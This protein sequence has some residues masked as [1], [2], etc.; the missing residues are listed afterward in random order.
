MAQLRDFV[1]EHADQLAQLLDK[2]WAEAPVTP[3]SAEP[4]LSAEFLAT[5]ATSPDRALF[6]ALVKGLAGTYGAAEL[7]QPGAAQAYGLTDHV[8]PVRPI[9][10]A[11]ASKNALPK[12]FDR[13][14][15]ERL[16]APL[17]NA[18][19]R[20]SLADIPILVRQEISRSAGP[21]QLAEESGRVVMIL[22]RDASAPLMGGPAEGA[23]AR[24]RLR[25][26]REAYVHRV[27]RMPSDAPESIRA[28][29]HGVREA[30]LRRLWV[31]VHGR[32]LR[33]DTIVADELWDMLDGVLR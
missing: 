27:L 7:D 17:T 32:E 8:R 30:Y 33:R 12:P 10:G 15:V 21:W 24:L 2:T 5:C 26:E 23:A 14:I 31:R 3:R 9:L 13:S 11:T 20:A 29:V 25:W 22:G 1:A 28:D 18:A 6:K 16:F 4:T 19:Y